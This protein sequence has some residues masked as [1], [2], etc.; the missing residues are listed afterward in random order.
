MSEQHSVGNQEPTERDIVHDLRGPLAAIQAC[1][2]LLGDEICG[3]LNEEQHKQ[4]QAVLRNVD[5]LD[6]M[7]ASL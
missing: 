5:R 7:I 3:G 6:E 4:I 2:E 1:A